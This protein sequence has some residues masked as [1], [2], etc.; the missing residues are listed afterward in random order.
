MDPIKVYDTTL[1]DG[2]QGENINFS[3]E[4]KIKIAGE[5]Q[6]RKPVI[7]QDNVW[8]VCFDD[9]S[10]DL[11]AVSAHSDNGSWNRLGDHKGFVT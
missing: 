9:I 4:D 6:V 7:Q 1:R 5:F 2:T 3:A 11:R 10:G 8:L